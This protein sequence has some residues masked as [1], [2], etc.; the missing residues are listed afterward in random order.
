MA[1]RLAHE[2][3]AALAAKI[4]T[5]LLIGI[6]VRELTVGVEFFETFQNFVDIS[7][8]ISIVIHRGIGLS[9]GGVHFHSYH[10]ARIVLRIELALAHVAAKV[11]HLR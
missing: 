11:N 2:A 10:V 6:V 8:I 4:K 9:W 7:K 5:P 3:L 1:Q